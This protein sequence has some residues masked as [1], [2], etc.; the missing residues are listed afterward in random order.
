MSQLLDQITIP[1]ACPV[2]WE[3]MKGTD[4]VRSCAD[5]SRKVYNLSAMSEIEA[6]N[7]LQ[8]HGTSECVQF[9]RRIDGKIMTDRCPAILRKVR[10]RTINAA[11]L[12]MGILVSLFAVSK[13]NA[14]VETKWAPLTRDQLRSRQQVL[15]ANAFLAGSVIG[16]IGTFTGPAKKKSDDG[17]ESCGK[18]G[19]H[20]RGFREQQS[21][22]A[23]NEYKKARDQRAKN[24]LVRSYSHYERAFALAKKLECAPFVLPTIKA[25]QSE[26]KAELDKQKQ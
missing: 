6:E 26:V 9:F 5:C 1:V 3:S 12:V 16:G 25:E 4:Q 10:N 11:S 23:Y 15:T 8:T 17:K 7:F 13:A 19:W 21:K 14:E 20:N 24:K 2:L 18:S 22:D